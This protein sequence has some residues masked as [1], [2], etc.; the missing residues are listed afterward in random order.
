MLQRPSRTGELSVMVVAPVVDLLFLT[1]A[2]SFPEIHFRLLVSSSHFLVVYKSGS[3]VEVRVRVAC[4]IISQ[5]HTLTS[6]LP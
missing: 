1:E 4:N 2:V 6:L 3:L 5:N